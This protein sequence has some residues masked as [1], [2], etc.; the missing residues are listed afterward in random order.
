MNGMGGTEIAALS[1]TNVSKYYG[2][3]GSFSRKLIRS[4]DDV[5]FSLRRG[6]VLGIVGES[7]SGKTTLARLIMGLVCPTSGQICVEGQDIALL[8]PEQL[9]RFRTRIQLIFQ[10]PYGALNPRMPVG[11]AI[12]S[13]LRQHGWP[14][15]EAEQTLT[16]ALRQVGLDDS[17]RSRWPGECS[18]GQLQR[19]AIARA[20]ALRPKI[21]I[22]DEPTSALDASMR[23]HIL[24][25]L[26]DLQTKLKL[27]VIMISHDMR[28]IQHLCDR[29]AVMY[30]GRIVE[31]GGKERLFSHPRHPYTRALINASMLEKNGLEGMPCLDAFGEPP[32]P[33]N[34]LPGCRYH[35]RCHLADEVCRNIEPGLLN[36][37]D[38]LVACH[39]AGQNKG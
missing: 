29:V 1:V 17:Y 36:D 9:R 18:G 8:S 23:A 26:A 21:L 30:F 31:L 5:S 34:P 39:K 12:S 22:C 16:E 38:V 7:G 25:L 33:I 19:I 6:E 37:T 15:E 35:S 2:F 3:G 28:V 4:V 13:P 14:K 11:E 32:S 20:L 10:N 27:S 24:N